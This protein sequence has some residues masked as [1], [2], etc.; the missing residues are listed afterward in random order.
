MELEAGGSGSSNSNGT[1]TSTVSVNTTAG[2][3]IVLTQEMDR[4]KFW[5]GLIPDSFTKTE[6][7]GTNG[8]ATQLISKLFKIKFYSKI[9]HQLVIV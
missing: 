8:H 4:H 9:R 6:L 2:F 1:I 7:S 5:H 3:S